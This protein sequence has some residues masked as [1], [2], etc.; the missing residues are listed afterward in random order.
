MVGQQTAG[1]AARWGLSIVGEFLIDRGV[2]PAN[3]R[4][5]ADRLRRLGVERSNLVTAG[6]RRYA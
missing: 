2:R 6:P 5:F 3:L 4:E 1:R